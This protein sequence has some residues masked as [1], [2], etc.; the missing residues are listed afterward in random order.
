MLINCR[1]SYPLLGKYVSVTYTSRP[2]DVL[3]YADNN[4]FEA[5]P[6]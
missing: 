4:P 2:V 6:A 1:Y 3:N 5:Y